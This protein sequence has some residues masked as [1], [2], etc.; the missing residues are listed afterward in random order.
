MQLL[1]YVAYLKQSGKKLEVIAIN[2]VHI[3]FEM[4]LTKQV[5]F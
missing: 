1:K 5:L 3:L 2:K 4:L